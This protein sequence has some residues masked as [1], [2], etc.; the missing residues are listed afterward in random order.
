MSRRTVGCNGGRDGDGQK[1]QSVPRAQGDLGVQGDLSVQGDQNVQVIRRLD[2]DLQHAV[3]A[4]RVLRLSSRETDPVT[5]ILAAQIQLR[6]WRRMDTRM[7]S[8]GRS[9]GDSTGDS[10]E[11]SNGVRQRISEIV[12][13]RDELM[14][15][16]VQRPHHRLPIERKAE[17]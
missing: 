14:G 2:R 8:T 1:L 11:G 6:R 12:A 15:R 10:T 7:G 13:A 5:I 4:H 3:A 17:A 16:A 9:M